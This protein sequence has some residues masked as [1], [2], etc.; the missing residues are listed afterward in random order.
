MG[1]KRR[2]NW[3]RTQPKFNVGRKQKGPLFDAS[4]AMVQIY[5][6]KTQ[7]HVKASIL[8]SA[9]GRRSRDLPSLE[10]VKG[11]MMEPILLT[12]KPVGA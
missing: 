10:T 2:L 9:Y 12:T 7:G 5:G 6:G 4:Q 3:P 8:G 11:G 1:G